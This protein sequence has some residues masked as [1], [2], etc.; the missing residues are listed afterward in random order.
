LD[1]CTNDFPA[2]GSRSPRQEAQEGQQQQPQQEEAEGQ[3]TASVNLEGGPQ[4]STLPVKWAKFQ[5][6]RISSRYEQWKRL[7]TDR[8]LL[9]DVK[10]YTIEFDEV[11]YQRYPERPLR[12]S[13]EEM[14]FAKEEIVQLLQKGVLCEAQHEPDE[15]I[16]NVFLRPKKEKGRYRMILNLKKLNEFV[17][18][19]HFKMDTLETVLTLIR[20]GM[21]MAS[22]DFT[23]AYYSLAIAQQH[24][25]YLRFEFEDVLY[26]FTCLPNGL[27]SG[28]RVFTKILKVPLAWLRESFGI[29]ISGYI[30]DTIL[31]SESAEQLRA[32]LEIA[33]ELFQDLGFMISWKK[34]VLEP[35]QEIE[36][37]GFLIN[38]VTGRVSLPVAKADNIVRMVRKALSQSEFT[39]REIAQLLGVLVATSPGNRWAQLYTKALDIEKTEALRANYGNYEAYMS[40]SPIVY[41]DLEWWKTNVRMVFSEIW[42]GSRTW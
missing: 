19:H 4:V 25:K 31:C 11:P 33:A 5:A 10:A 27:S 20:P 39:I 7:T 13:Q 16:S 3:L 18:Y 1:R 17:T 41:E 12:F 32:D 42:G 36:F 29:T 22:I 37:L 24:R 2:F 23:D 30:D 34:S 40:V 14:H 35:V 9:K 15:F 38:S 26:E 8:L 28:P 21:F 6:G